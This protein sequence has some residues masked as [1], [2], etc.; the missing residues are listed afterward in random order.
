VIGQVPA[1]TGQEPR[2]LLTRLACTDHSTTS[3]TDATI[4]A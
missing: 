4:A 3:R 1:T 2:V